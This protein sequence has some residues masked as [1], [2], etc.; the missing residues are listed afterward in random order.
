MLEHKGEGHGLF[1]VVLD[2]NR[3]GSLDLPGRAVRIVLAVAEPFAEV[4]AVLHFNDGNVSVLG[5]GLD[6]AKNALK[7]CQQENAPTYS[8]DLL[9]LR[10][11]AVL[12]E[13]AEESLLAVQSLADLIEALY[14]S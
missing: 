13:D 1:S 7:G 10:I 12:G 6:S 14:E 8:D 5:E 4:L 2:G 9:V 3:R 11:I